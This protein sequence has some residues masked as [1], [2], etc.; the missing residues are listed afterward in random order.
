MNS[1]PRRLRILNSL[2]SRLPLEELQTL[3][4]KLETFTL[5]PGFLIISE[6][7]L[8]KSRRLLYYYWNEH[9]Y[10]LSFCDYPEGFSVFGF[11]PG[12]LKLILLEDREGKEP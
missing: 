5:F 2:A 8:K 3:T 1:R 6:E 4:Q 7:T 12:G 11:V 10:K 9:E